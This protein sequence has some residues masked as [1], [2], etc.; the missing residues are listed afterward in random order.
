MRHC[1][2]L[3]FLGLTLAWMVFAPLAWAQPDSE[4]GGFLEKLQ[5]VKRSQLGPTLGVEQRTVDQLLK[6]DQKYT[7]LKD[8]ARRE[9]K[10]T[11]QQLHQLMRNPTPAEAEVQALLDNLRRQE[12]EMH[13]LKQRETEEQ[14]AILSPVQQARYILYLQQMMKEARSIKGGPG[15]MAPMIPG[16]PREIPVSRPGR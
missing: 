3:S 8:Q 5:E 10:A 2:L 15:G 9:F 13:N 6:I 14:R 11:F 4:S 7:P 12:Q 1:L 16:G